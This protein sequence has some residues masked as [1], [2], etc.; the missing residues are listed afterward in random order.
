MYVDIGTDFLVKSSDIIGIF[1]L[2]NTTTTTGYTNN[3]LNEKQKQGKVVYLVKDLPKSFVL[4]QDG[5]V[6]VVELASQI[7][8]KRLE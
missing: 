3:F 8:R 6:Y 4:T 5:T 2:D 1:D 7:I